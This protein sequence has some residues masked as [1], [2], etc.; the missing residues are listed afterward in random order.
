M[1]PRKLISQIHDSKKRRYPYG[2]GYCPWEI[3][4]QDNGFKLIFGFS[5]PPVGLLSPF[6]FWQKCLETPGKKKTAASC[7]WNLT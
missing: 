1:P 2:K 4:A 7:N 5:Q 3:K 6:E